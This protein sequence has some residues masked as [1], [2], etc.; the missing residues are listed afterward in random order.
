MSKKPTPAKFSSL[1]K[2]LSYKFKDENLLKLALTHN[3]FGKPNNQSLE[4][5]G[6]SLLGFLVAKLLF[7]WHPKSGEGHLSTSRS[8]VVKNEN[9]A[10]YS[11]YLGI[12]NLLITAK[13]KPNAPIKDQ[14][15]V[16]ADAL[17][18][19]LAAMYLDGGIE[20]VEQLVERIVEESL[21]P[22]RRN[23]K[24]D[25]GVEV[26]SSNAQLHPKS[27]LQEFVASSSQSNPPKYN[28]VKSTNLPADNLWVVLCT[29]GGITTSGEATSKKKAETLAAIA[30]LTKLGM[31]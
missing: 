28:V 27:R 17:E 14:M 13:G 16:R 1:E 24:A 15:K 22:V 7:D 29:V 8:E 26:K 4:F 19:L 9:L 3:S 2:E 23:S 30:M 5:L 10:D 18:A 11:E 21:L 20:P 12:P 25:S 31:Q 6:D